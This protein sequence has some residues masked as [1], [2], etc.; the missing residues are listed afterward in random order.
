[1]DPD[2]SPSAIDITLACPD[3]R[4]TMPEVEAEARR[5]V[6]AALAASGAKAGAVS[7][8]LADNETVR[9][10][11]LRFRGKDKPTNVLSFPAAPLPAG[12]PEPPLGDL[13]LAFETLRDEAEAAGKPFAHH[14]F[15]LLVHGTLHLLGHTHEG[16]EDEARMM[17]GERVILARLDVPDPYEGDRAGGRGAG[18]PGAD[19]A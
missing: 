16:D 15:H 17:A 1:M 5:A 14:F 11:N 13:A 18:R 7:V 8:L 10:L 3:W 12:T 4:R 9:A 19:A 6:G 2:D